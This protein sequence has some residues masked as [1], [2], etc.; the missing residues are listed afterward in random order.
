MKL[1][2]KQ[3]VGKK[4]RCVY[5]PAK[6]PLQ[7]L[8]LSGVI[9]A[10]KQQELIEVAQALDPIRLFQQIEQLQQAIFRC[11]VNYPPFV[12]STPPAP[13][14]IFSVE[15]CTAGN[16]PADRSVPDLATVFQ[17]R[18][19]EQVRRKQVLGW[20]RTRKDPFDGEWEQILSWLVINPERPQRRHLPGIALPL[21]WTLSTITNPYSPA[22]DAEDPSSPTGNF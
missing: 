20:R 1:Q 14:R 16:I 9:S 5:D 13:L 6:T 7:R 4:V 17:T 19:R 15:H 8:L 12:S 11:A 22:W 18:Y 2:S 10:Q 21:P 3:R